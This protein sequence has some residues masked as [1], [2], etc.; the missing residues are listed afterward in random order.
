MDE[1]L[2]GK[3]ES[4][5]GSAAPESCLRRA[6]S[7]LR[8]QIARL[9]LPGR[10]GGA[11]PV[12][13]ASGR[14]RLTRIALRLGGLVLFLAL[15]PFLLTLVYAVVPPVSTLMIARVVTLQP[16]SRHWLPLEEISPT[17][18]KSVV[19]SEDARFCTHNGVDFIEL[20][21][22][23]AEISDGGPSRGASTIT[24]QVA[25]N[26]FLWQGRSYIR[27]GIEIPIAFWIDFALSK[28]RVLEIYM[29]TVEWG[30]DGQFGAEAG[31][32]AAFG[33][34]ATELT[35]TEAALMATALPNPI[36][37]NPENPSAGQ[38]R[39]AR[40]L[41]ARV[42]QSGDLTGCVGDLGSSAASAPAPSVTPAPPRPSPLPAGSP[43]LPPIPP[44]PPA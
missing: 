9:P 27:K 14:E 30:P 36:L 7:A 28:R 31:A 29:N 23:L 21:K 12:A 24:M 15:L 38:R 1:T 37:R 26:L 33:R 17:L 4:P 32:Q 16:A 40:N 8:R 11:A 41:L 6:L 20:N 13:P 42:R 18:V 2:T 19:T 43:V 5:A 10:T 39:L 25:R 3:P 44:R 22:V 35:P 34:S